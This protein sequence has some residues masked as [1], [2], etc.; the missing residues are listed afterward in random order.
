MRFPRYRNWYS[1][2]DALNDFI[3]AHYWRS[4][5]I[6][7]GYYSADIAQKYRKEFSQAFSFKA[8]SIY[9]YRKVKANR[10]WNISR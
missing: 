1:D 10:R 7:W 3:N 8:R 6:I 2:R 9:R 5:G 4:F